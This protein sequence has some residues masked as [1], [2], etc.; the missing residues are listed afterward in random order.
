MANLTPDDIR[1][2]AKLARLNLTDEEVAKLP[3]QL[4][5]IL[6]YVDMLQE[7]DTTGVEPA[8][9]ATGLT[10]VV[11]EDVIQPSIDG[12]TLVKTTGLQVSERQ[13]VTPSAHD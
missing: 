8:A 2:I 9:Q 7:V 4:S 3:E 12:E 6:N 1:H 10:T 13:I 11:R 5:S